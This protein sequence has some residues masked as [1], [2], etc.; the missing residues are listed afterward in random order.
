MNWITNK[1]AV[2]D[3]QDYI[4]R[5]K[6]RKIGVTPVDVREFWDESDDAFEPEDIDGLVRSINPDEKVMIFCDAG[7]DRSPFVA[8]LYLVINKNLTF[9]EAYT[10]VSKGRPQTI[11][12]YEWA[13]EME[14]FYDGNVPVD[15]PEPIALELEEDVEIDE[16]ETCCG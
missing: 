9:S 15:A 4:N 16:D 13:K 6:L 7:M 10:L 1:L 12:H 8:A 5:R 2:G 14:S 3:I 11:T